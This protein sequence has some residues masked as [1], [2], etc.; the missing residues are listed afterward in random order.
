MED[1]RDGDTGLYWVKYW[2]Q[3]GQYTSK[4]LQHAVKDFKTHLTLN[5]YSLETD[6][7]RVC[8]CYQAVLFMARLAYHW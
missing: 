4:T 8:W 1:S 2:K 7:V 3:C 6:E 5:F